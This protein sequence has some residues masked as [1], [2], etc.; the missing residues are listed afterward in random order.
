MGTRSRSS[1]EVGG[2]I[3]HVASHISDVPYKLNSIACGIRRRKRF[4]SKVGRGSPLLTQN[5]KSGSFALRSS[6]KTSSKEAKNVGTTQSR[7]TLRS[8]N[9]RTNC[10]GSFNTSSPTITVGVPSNS[11]PSSS[12]SESTKESEV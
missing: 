7:L 8:A 4:N 1:E 9:C 12:Q 2:G 11:G 5:F 6:E 10:T 3:Y